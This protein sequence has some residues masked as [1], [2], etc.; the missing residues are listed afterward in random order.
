LEFGEEL[1]P[2]V[3][4]LRE[5]GLG[6]GAA[7]ATQFA[8]QPAGKFGHRFTGI[9]VAGGKQ[10]S[11][12]FSALA[13]AQRAFEAIEPARAGNPALS[14]VLETLMRFAAEVMADF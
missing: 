7:L 14:Y 2:L 13:N 11:P 9:A 6:D 5:E 1:A 8:E 10:D 4:E 12:K 3:P